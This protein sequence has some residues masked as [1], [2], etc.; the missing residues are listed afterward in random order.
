MW[1]DRDDVPGLEPTVVGPA[2][3][4]FRCLVVRGRDPDAAHL[5]LAHGLAVPGDETL[6]TARPHFDERGRD[7]LLGAVA[8]LLLFRER[9][10]PARELRD[11][12]EWAHLR[13]A[14]RVDDSQPVPLLERLDHRLRR[15]RAADDHRAHRRR[16]VLAW[17]RVELSEDPHPD[18]RHARGDRDLLL[19]ER[20]EQ[21]LPV[22]ER[23]GK[24]LLRADER[25][26][27]GEAPGV[28]M[29]H[30][31]DGERRVL[32]GH[33]EDARHRGRERVHGDRSVGVERSLRLPGCPARVAHGSGG[34]L[35]DLAVGEIAGLG[36]GD[37]ILVLDG[38][39]RGRSVAYCD[40]V[41]EAG[42]LAEVLDE[43][44]E[45]LV[46]DEDAV[47]RVCRDVGEVVRVEPEVEGVR[48]HAADGDADVGLEVLVVV[49]AERSDAVAVAQPELLAKRRGKPS[50]PL[51]E[52]RVRVAVPAAI[53][54][55]RGDLPLAEELLGAAED[56]R[57]VELVV[58]D[59]AFHLSLLVRRTR[60]PAP[61]PAPPR[62]SR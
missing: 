50:C 41:L 38:A 22:E 7:A 62:S 30:G 47:A 10:L 54:K 26:G 14:P 29:E 33:G 12:A 25:A 53:G 17:I 34:S 35:V 37:E 43:G 36:A 11:G 58:H 4:T 19:L 51:P 44:P 9:Q 21:A 42:A 27:E 40:D 45:H 2:I 18:R 57:D 31:D 55:P 13:H 28:R 15:G 32:L 3:G 52:L 16:V 49:P 8:E 20:L 56:R 46:R 61:R 48:D 6:C 59:Q 24:D 39:V 60:E 1:L 23:A 5:E